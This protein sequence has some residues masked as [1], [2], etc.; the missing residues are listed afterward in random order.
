MPEFKKDNKFSLGQKIPAFVKPFSKQEM[1]SG[2]FEAK[3]SSILRI[4]T[5]WAGHLEAIFKHPEFSVKRRTSAYKNIH[6]E[7][8]ELRRKKGTNSIEEFINRLKSEAK[9]VRRK[10]MSLTKTSYEFISKFLS[11]GGEDE[12]FVSSVNRFTETR[13]ASSKVSAVLTSLMLKYVNILIHHLLRAGKSTF[14]LKNGH[15]GYENF[16]LV[17]FQVSDLLRSKYQCS[18]AGFINLLK[19]MYALDNSNS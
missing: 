10:L 9:E 18:E 6:N 14:G 13:T 8:V 1:Q 4:L 5:K 15:L 12:S 7:L 2:H 11:E 17:T 3:H 19:T 16:N